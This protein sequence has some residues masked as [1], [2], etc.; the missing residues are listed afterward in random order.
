MSSV[1]RQVEYYFSDHSWPFDEYLK[2][3]AVSG[4]D[5]FVDLAVIAGFG[6]MKEL[7]P[8]GDVATI[9]ASLETS[10]SVQ[11]NA[12]QTGAKRVHPVPLEDPALKRTVHVAQFNSD[13]SRA[14]ISAA[15][16]VHGEVESVRF[17][18]NLAADDRA[19]DGSA[20]VVFALEASATAACE[21]CAKGEVPGDAG[22]AGAKPLAQYYDEF[23][24]RRE[25]MRKKR[26]GDDDAGGEGAGGQSKKRQKQE[27]APF[28]ENY[29]KGLVLKMGG[30]EGTG[31]DRE[32]VK[33]ALEAFGTVGWVEYER[34]G[35]EA[36]VRFNDEGAA[37]AAVTAGTVSMV[38]VPATP[39]A[40][41]E[42]G[43]AEEPAEEPAA[44]ASAAPAVPVT[45]STLEVLEGDAE[46][47]Y[48]VRKHEDG[49][50]RLAS[51]GKGRGKGK[52]GKG[53][54]RRGG[55]GKGNRR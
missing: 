7:V 15:F 42:D 33:E 43:A 44:A 2:S 31:V 25:G 5:G 27:V 17:G 13:E 55:K 36:L 39:T 40:K 35:A 21:A 50:K 10:D 8:D 4:T 22:P 32:A 19:F 53:K 30:L 28:D 54:G 16:G 29:T 38:V 52:G 45:T 14:G 9:A 20:L 34:D 18:R 1:L 12:S 24:K 48:W 6:K 49:A 11:L 41:E 3:L 26:G 47:G 51:R 37:A 46:R 23:V